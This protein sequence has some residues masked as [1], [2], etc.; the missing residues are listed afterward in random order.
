MGT[1]LLGVA[2]GDCPVGV[3]DPEGTDG[4]VAAGRPLVNGVPVVLDTFSISALGS[5]SCVNVFFPDIC[6]A[7]S[8]LKKTKKKVKIKAAIKASPETAF[9]YLVILL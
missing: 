6:V 5:P 7:L 8:R 9:I 3:C 4:I 1:L 2:C